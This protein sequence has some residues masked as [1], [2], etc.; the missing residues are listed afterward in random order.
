MKRIVRIECKAWSTRR[1]ER[2]RGG[3]ERA[4]ER[5]RRTKYE[6][7]VCGF[8]RACSR[9]DISEKRSI[10]WSA[11]LSNGA[12]HGE[13]R[14]NKTKSSQFVLNIRTCPTN[15]RHTLEFQ[16]ILSSCVCFI[17]FI[18]SA[19]LHLRIKKFNLL[20]R[21]WSAK[22]YHNAPKIRLQYAECCLLVPEARKRGS[23]T[24]NKERAVVVG[25][26]H[27]LNA[28]GRSGERKKMFQHMIKIN[29][30]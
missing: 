13:E 18:C 28:K 1:R 2:E 17:S 6:W 22:A 10:D 29:S 25:V 20:F 15:L 8:G 11:T 4:A 5:E 30:F 24:S 27:H 9:Y 21:D 14:R 12:S 3:K 16:F 26:A 19:F 23:S 7:I